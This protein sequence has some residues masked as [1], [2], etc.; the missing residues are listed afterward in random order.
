[1]SILIKGMEMPTNGD[2]VE[3]LIWSDGHVT[4]TGDSYRAENGRAYYKP[5][6]WEYFYAVGVSPHG[7]LIDADVLKEKQQA[8]AD[9][10]KGSTDYGEKCRRD[11]ALNAVANIVNAPTIIEAEA[12][13]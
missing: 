8:D 4:K 11:E 7:R 6:D 12:D 9:L 3:L 1:M 10:F 13:E 2:F 5:C